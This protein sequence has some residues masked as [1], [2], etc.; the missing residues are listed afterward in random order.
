[1]LSNQKDSRREIEE[2]MNLPD[3]LGSQK[4]IHVSGGQGHSLND[5]ILKDMQR[6]NILKHIN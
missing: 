3:N 5:E 6:K 2:V 4:K 1:L